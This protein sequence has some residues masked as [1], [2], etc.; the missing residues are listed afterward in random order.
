MNQLVS[1]RSAGI[2]CP[3]C[4]QKGQRITCLSGSKSEVVVYHP[5]KRFHTT[6]RISCTENTQSEGEEIDI[7]VEPYETEVAEAR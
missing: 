3:A 7:N 2:I 6:C 4:G 1:V 5:K